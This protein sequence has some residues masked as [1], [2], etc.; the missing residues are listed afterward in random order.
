MRKIWIPILGIL[1]VSITIFTDNKQTFENDFTFIGSTILQ[2]ISI[3]SLLIYFFFYNGSW[4]VYCGIS[5]ISITSG[6]DCVLLPLKETN[7][8]YHRYSPATLPIFGKY[9]DYGGIEHCN[10]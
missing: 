9:N 2:T 4:S 3:S 10:R 8:E 6:N 1:I 5:N 7:G